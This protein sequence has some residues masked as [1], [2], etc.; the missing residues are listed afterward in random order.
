MDRVFRVLFKVFPKRHDVVVNRSGVGEGVVAPDNF[1]DFFTADDLS[2]FGNQ[3]AEELAFAFGDALRLACVGHNF[4]RV[5]IDGDA[6]I[7]IE[8]P[9]PLNGFNVHRTKQ[10]LTTKNEFIDM[11]GPSELIITSCLESHDPVS[12]VVFGGKE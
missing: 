9:Q 8:R 11:K 7:K 3:E 1:E 6:V 2:C 4:K 12:T 10:T 5:K